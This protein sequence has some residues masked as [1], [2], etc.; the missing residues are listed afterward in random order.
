MELSA[1][2]PDFDSQWGEYEFDFFFFKFF[3]VYIPFDDF[4]PKF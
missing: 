1:R 2:G 4:K 3:G